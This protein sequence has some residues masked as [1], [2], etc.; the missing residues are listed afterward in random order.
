ML[1]IDSA[2]T[3][4]KKFNEDTSFFARTSRGGRF[5]GDRQIVSNK[6]E[7]DGSLNLAGKKAAVDIVNQHELGVK[8]R[9]EFLDGRYTFEMTLLKGDFKQSTYELTA[10]KCPGGAGGCIVD[11]RFRSS[12]AEAFATYRRGGFSLIANATYA[13][14]EKSGFN[15][16][17][18]SLPFSRAPSIPDLSYTVSANYDIGDRASVGLSSTGQTSA[19]DN[20]GFEYPSSAVF[21]AVVR[22]QLIKDLEL[23]LQ[24]YNLFD[25]FDAR[26]NGSV[27]KNAGNQSV[28]N[29]N[30][31]LGR[32]ITAA[33][34]YSF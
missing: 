19:V 24:A 2:Y 1:T 32:T 31:A 5:N 26:G 7:A 10:T 20:D 11:A 28:I 30:P 4:L 14:A 9:G 18:E 15:D 29:V 33:V 23:S 25:T 27:A 8:N 6:I 12:G 16:K 13:K 17:G 21:N 3:K 34:R 22:Y